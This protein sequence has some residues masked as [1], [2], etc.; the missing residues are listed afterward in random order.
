MSLSNSNITI[1]SRK[2][3]HISCSAFGKPLPLVKWY[4]R[5]VGEEKVEIVENVQDGALSI[6]ET[7]KKDKG[8]Y[9]CVASN[10]AGSA[11]AELQLDVKG[12]ICS[13]SILIRLIEIC[14]LFVNPSTV[15]FWGQIIF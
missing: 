7:A 10:K 6:N 14:L 2:P 12:L 4:K 13:I 9:V 1:V 8:L 3:L 15:C 5:R 11:E